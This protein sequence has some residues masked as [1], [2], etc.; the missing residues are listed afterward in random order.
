MNEN[1]C[2][3][4]IKDNIQNKSLKT[5]SKYIQKMLIIDTTKQKELFDSIS[6]NQLNKLIDEFINRVSFTG[7]KVVLLEELKNQN[8]RYKNIINMIKDLLGANDI[9]EK[10][11]LSKIFQLIITLIGITILYLFYQLGYAFLYGYYFGGDYNNTIS[12]LDM[13]VCP[14][15]FNF[16]TMIALGVFFTYIY[17]CL[18]TNINIVYPYK[19]QKGQVFLLFIVY[20]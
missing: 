19:K 8:N 9:I 17:K 7:K 5:D 2:L 18:F 3:I 4:I 14:V 15:P 20:T 11:Q 10:Y 16:K 13:Y 1:D 6:K 12:V